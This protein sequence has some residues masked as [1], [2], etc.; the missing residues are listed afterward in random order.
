MSDGFGPLD[1]VLAALEGLIVSSAS[2]LGLFV[3]FCVLAG[4]PRWRRRRAD[5]RVVRSLDEA[6]GRPLRYTSP[7]APHGRVDQLHPSGTSSVPAP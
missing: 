5:G 2:L 3:G 7:D 6:L 4:L 1:G